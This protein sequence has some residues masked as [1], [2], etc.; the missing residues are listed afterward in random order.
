MPMNWI[1]RQTSKTPLS[2]TQGEGWGVH[3]YSRATGPQHLAGVGG[4]GVTMDYYNCKAGLG[5]H[6]WP[7]A[8]VCA[9]EA[10]ERH[11]PNTVSSQHLTAR[12]IL[13]YSLKTFVLQWPN[14]E[15]SYRQA[16]GR[17]VCC[18]GKYQ[19]KQK[20]IR[21]LGFTSEWPTN[22]FQGIYAQDS[23]PPPKF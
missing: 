14:K 2:R 8:S 7:W 9:Y 15:E 19:A 10:V 1:P 5:Y 4:A 18:A 6:V 20:E 3:S 12:S 16:A 13:I 11:L 21:A 22:T 17:E 23:C